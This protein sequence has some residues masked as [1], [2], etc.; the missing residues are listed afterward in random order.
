MSDR[1]SR[2]LAV[3]LHADV[4]GSTALVQKDESLSHERIQAAFKRLSET[5]HA[6]G[7]VAHEIRGDA[8]V[9]EFSRASDAV[10]AG[11]AFQT[12]N[13]EYNTGIEDEIRPEI[14]VGISLGEVVIADG[15]V[16]GAGVVLAQRL[17]QLAQPNGIV[18]Q[19][20]VSE[21]VPARMPFDFDNLG[22]QTLK[23]FDQPVRAFAVSLKD[24]LPIPESDPTSQGARTDLHSRDNLTEGSQTPFAY[25][26]SLAVLP[27]NT[28]GHSSKTEDLADGIA[29]VVINTMLRIGQTDIVDTAT[30]F[31]YK[32]Q[33]IAPTEVAQALS[34]QYVLQG[35]VQKFGSRIRITA[36]LFD[37]ESGSNLWS[38][39]YDRHFEDP[40]QL[41]D[42]IAQQI[43]RSVRT[44]VV[45]GAASAEWEVPNESF[46]AWILNL[47]GVELLFAR[48]GAENMRHVQV[49]FEDVMALDPNYPYGPTNSAWT[50]IYEYIYGWSNSS[51][52]S[53]AKA[54]TLAQRTF[55]ID[56]ADVFA[57]KYGVLGV[58]ELLRGEY[59]RALE[60]ADLNHTGIPGDSES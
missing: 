27:F 49:L 38:E 1:P 41:Q 36:E 11:L 17:E 52:E 8:L 26:P 5:T 57:Y 21:T 46:D 39:R 58:V 32:G 14:R 33:S 31:T 48:G 10:C 25:K 15:T 13:T 50:H 53:L 54:L 30:A 55:E 6:Y 9:A 56:E 44:C 42:E 60:L 59:D 22:E 28:V 47:Q 37:A 12:K 18:V 43:T 19:G 40:F 35:T 29:H 20:T 3:I 7:G 34:V 23:G 51:E 2:Q 45:W 16:T 24:G 4:V